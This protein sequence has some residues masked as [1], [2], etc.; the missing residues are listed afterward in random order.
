MS[1]LHQHLSSQELKEIQLIS[2]KSLPSSNQSLLNHNK[3]AALEVLLRVQNSLK[4]A[5]AHQVVRT[6]IVT[7]T[8]ES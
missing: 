1:A 8:I 5:T 7:K 2:E 4:L 3:A 6:T